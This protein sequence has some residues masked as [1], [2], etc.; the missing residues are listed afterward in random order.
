M[1]LY[2]KKLHTPK[3]QLFIPVYPYGILWHSE[4]ALLASTPPPSSP[5]RWSDETLK[6]GGPAIDSQLVIYPG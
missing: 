5:Q 3:G 4:G 2:Q 1:G 6:D